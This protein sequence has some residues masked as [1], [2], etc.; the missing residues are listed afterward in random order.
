MNHCKWLLTVLLVTIGHLYASTLNELCPILKQG[1]AFAYRC[2]QEIAIFEVETVEPLSIAQYRLK[3]YEFFSRKPWTQ[4]LE[5]L[6]EQ[7][8]AK[9]TTPN[10]LL[11]MLLKLE[12]YPILKERS[13]RPRLDILKHVQGAIKWELFQ[14]KL[15]PDFEESL[16]GKR[17]VL[18]FPYG[19]G[20]AKLGLPQHWPYWIENHEHVHKWVVYLVGYHSTQHPPYPLPSL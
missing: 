17:I 1:D 5:T 3:S 2:G 11:S 8:D 13:W 7:P 9:I 14:A 10:N 16:A 4:W 18:Y 15:E 19:E 6:K 20:V 12:L